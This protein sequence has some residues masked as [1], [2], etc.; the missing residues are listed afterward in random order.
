MKSFQD[1]GEESRDNFPGLTILKACSLVYYSSPRACSQHPLGREAKLKEVLS[2]ALGW[3]WGWGRHTCL[4][5]LNASKYCDNLD[6][7][8][9]DL[10][11]SLNKKQ[12][13]ETI[14]I[15]KT[16]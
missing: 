11:V 7:E 12:L 10:K 3:R 2:Y 4:Y 5:E 9:R 16:P 8:S 15:M 6:F 14:A 13:D 1:G